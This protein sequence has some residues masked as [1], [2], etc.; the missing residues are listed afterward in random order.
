MR[1]E[2]DASRSSLP[3]LVDADQSTL[4]GWLRENQRTWTCKPQAQALLSGT[5]FLR[6][7]NCCQHSQ[8]VGNYWKKFGGLPDGEPPPTCA[9]ISLLLL[10]RQSPPRFAS[11]HVISKI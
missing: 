7:R 11:N 1:V 3:D 4:I 10:P 9:L 5:V 8:A 6:I 2:A